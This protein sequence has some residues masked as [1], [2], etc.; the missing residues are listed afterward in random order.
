[1]INR[2]NRRQQRTNCLWHVDQIWILASIEL[3]Q[4]FFNCGAVAY[5]IDCIAE[6]HGHLVNVGTR[7]AGAGQIPGRFVL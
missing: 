2:C 7:C 1:M 6:W 4:R 5:V 3:L